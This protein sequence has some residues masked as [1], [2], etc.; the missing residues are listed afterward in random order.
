MGEA[1]AIMGAHAL[2]GF[3]FANSMFKYHWQ[4]GND[5]LLN[6]VYYR[7]LMAKPSRKQLCG[8]VHGKKPPTWAGKPGDR[9][10]ETGWWVR[11]LRELPSGGPFLWFHYYHRCPACYKD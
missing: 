8:E 11:P 1:V 3:H 9:P 2:G 10:A 7:N 6:N 5:F 4:F